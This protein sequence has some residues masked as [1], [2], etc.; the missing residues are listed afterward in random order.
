MEHESSQRREDRQGQGGREH[1]DRRM[2][3]AVEELRSIQPVTGADLRAARHADERLFADSWAS[4]DIISD[5]VLFLIPALE[6]YPWQGK[7]LPRF[8]PRC[9]RERGWTRA[10]GFFR[11]RV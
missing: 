8:F 9:R 10:G 7:R 5:R 11:G 3:K 6:G 1:G 4:T 2:D